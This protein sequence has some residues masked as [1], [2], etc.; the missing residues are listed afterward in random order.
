MNPCSFLLFPCSVKFYFR[1][2]TLKVQVL[3]NILI[4]LFI[5]ETN[6]I[7]RHLSWLEKYSFTITLLV[8]G[9]LKDFYVN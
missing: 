6:R 7:M 8:T 9:I 3:I 4:I 5:I 2:H 1:L